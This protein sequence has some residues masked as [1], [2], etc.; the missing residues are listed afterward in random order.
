MDIDRYKTL[1]HWSWYKCCT[2]A[3]RDIP[4]QPRPVLLLILGVQPR[5]AWNLLQ[6]RNLARPAAARAA[7]AATVRLLVVVAVVIT[8]ARHPCTKPLG[9]QGPN[10]L[11]QGSYHSSKSMTYIE[12]RPEDI[13][14]MAYWRTAVDSG[15]HGFTGMHGQPHKDCYGPRIG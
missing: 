15:C 12:E 11:Q 13:D 1:S 9:S 3:R 5:S 6:A 14:L 4:S 10:Q 2:S 8:L 7:R